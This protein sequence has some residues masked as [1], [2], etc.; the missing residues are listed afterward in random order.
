MKKSL[1]LLVIMLAGVGLLTGCATKGTVEQE[2]A[3]AEARLSAKYDQLNTEV[4][5]NNQ[6]LQNLMKA[7]EEMQGRVDKAINEMAGFE[8]YTVIW[9][10]EINFAFDSYEIST[11]AEQILME[12]GEALERNPKA[13]AEF[14]GHTDRTGSSNYNIQ[15]G[16]ER[17]KA[18]KRFLTERF[19]ISLFRL[20]TVSHGERKPVAMADENQAASK[21]RRV[22]IKIWGP[23]QT[24]Q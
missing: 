23:P 7:Q 24:N 5:E 18:A 13:I 6:Q 19:G 15:L 2:V 22:S 11:N 16:E 12:A 17:A 1:T 8:S 10:G 3:D 20:F 4:A 14:E 9:S 21:N